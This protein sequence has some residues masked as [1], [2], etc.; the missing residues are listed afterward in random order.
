MYNF[1]RISADLV[2]QQ[3]SHFLSKKSADFY[4]EGFLLVG[5]GW[6]LFNTPLCRGFSRGSTEFLPFAE[7]PYNFLGLRHRSIIAIKL[8]FEKVKK[9][10]QVIRGWIFQIEGG[11]FFYIKL[12]IFSFWLKTNIKTS[13]FMPTACSFFFRF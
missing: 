6:G 12:Y 8:Q 10:N 9:I 7:S 3:I 13:S 11:K 5:E 2:T 1:S 4:G